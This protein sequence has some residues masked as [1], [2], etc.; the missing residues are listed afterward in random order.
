MKH[1]FYALYLAAFILSGC[2]ITHKQAPIEYHHRN[3]NAKNHK[4]YD[5][6]TVS[7]INNDSE[8][9]SRAEDVDYN[10][11]EVIK[12]KEI[13]E[14]DDENYVMPSQ[15]AKTEIKQEAKQVEKAAEKQVEKPAPKKLV[16]KIQEEPLKQ[17]QTTSEYLKPTNG[18]VISKFGQKTDYGINKGVNISAPEGSKVVASGAGKVIY[19]DFDATFGNLLIIKLNDKNIVLSYAHLESVAVSKGDSVKQGDVIGTIGSTGKVKQSQLHFAIRE[20]K[21]AV[22]PLKFV[23]Y[24]E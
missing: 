4:S 20:G 10:Q 14:S 18:K 21:T 17:V 6:R 11:E 2:T 24:N 7:V 15:R 19:A 22:D 3:S 5:E 13:A 9:I 1:C 12:P 16:T 8:I 23:S